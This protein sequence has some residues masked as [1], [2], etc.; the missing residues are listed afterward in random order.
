MRPVIFFDW[1]GTLADSIDL[2][3]HEVADAVREMGLPVPSAEMCRACNGPSLEKSAQMV[4]VP[5]ERIEE[6]RNL[7]RVCAVNNIPQYERLFP[8]VFGMIERLSEKADLV[9]MSNGCEE[10]VKTACSFLKLNDFFRIIQTQIPGKEKN[11]TLGILMD[12]L[13]PYAPIMVGDRLD[14][15][16]AG[17]DNGI[18]TL[19]AGYGYGGPEEGRDAVLTAQ[20]VWEMEQLLS[21]WAEDDG[22]R[23]RFSEGIG[24]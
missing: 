8:G 18:C 6:Y 16:N 24:K 9:I 17:K 22:F 14:D 4:G 19:Y 11:E 1:D 21:R 3:E 15:I 20:S 10:Y 5:F 23:R 7:R 12:L 13:R 2:T